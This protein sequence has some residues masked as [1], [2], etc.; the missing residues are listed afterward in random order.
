M[1]SCAPQQDA[2]KAVKRAAKRRQDRLDAAV[3]AGS[4]G[5]CREEAAPDIPS[6][7]GGRLHDM[8]AEAADVADAMAQQGASSLVRG[9][10]APAALPQ[11]PRGSQRLEVPVRVA[12]QL[13]ASVKILQWT[14]SSGVPRE[15]PLD[16]ALCYKGKIVAI[17]RHLCSG[18]RQGN[19]AL[20]DRVAALAAEFAHGVPAERNDPHEAG[21][22]TYFGRRWSRR[23][24]GVGV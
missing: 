18:E 20:V 2:K 1:L 22:M 10:P 21:I 14:P 4:A 17:H 24:G 5:A 11:L 23:S 3:A 7:A 12:D 19:A 6:G 9:L 16:T 15:L 8:A 13:P